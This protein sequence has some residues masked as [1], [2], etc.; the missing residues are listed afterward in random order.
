[1]AR[2]LARRL[3][4]SIIVVFGVSLLVFV[5]LRLSGDPT[6]MLL[7]VEAS[8]QDHAALRRSL[9]LDRP[10][11]EQ[12]LRFVGRAVRGDFGV[13]V[14]HRLP[15]LPTVLERF[16]ATMKLTLAGMLVAL[17]ISLPLGILSAARKNTWV[18]DV[19]RVTALL[20]QAMPTF[21]LGILLIMLF[22]VEL[23]WLPVVGSGDIRGLIL[24]AITLGAFAAPV[25]MRLLRSSLLEVLRTDYIRTARSKGLPQR[26]IFLKHALKNAAIPFVTVF[27]LQIGSWL[28]GAL[29]TEAVFAYPGM[30]LLAVNAI[31][32]IDLPVVQAYVVVV[33]LCILAVNFFVDLS[34]ALLDPRIRYG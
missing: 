18:D 23:E 29:V 28:G 22:A 30:G 2:Y 27:G 1:M 6:A 10:V 9:G 4:H 24:P 25:Q 12:Y 7:P 11:A 17:A 26:T 3:L 15:A 20:G 13:S 21:W 19:A 33:A 16:P 14:R 32:Q 31:Q 34:Y 5:L 8:P